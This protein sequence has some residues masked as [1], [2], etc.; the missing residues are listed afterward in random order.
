MAAWFLGLASLLAIYILIGYPIILALLRRRAAPAVKKNLDH[1]KT[2]TVILP[3]HNGAAFLAS[4]LESLL[5]QDYPRDLV[6]ILVASDGSTDATG[7]IARSYSDRGVRLISLP[8]GGKSAAVNG[9][10]EQARGDILFF[11]DVRQRLDTEALRHLVANFADPTVGAVTGEMVLTRGS[12]S[13][14]ANLDLYWRYE[15]WARRRHSEIDSV[16]NATGCIY[17]IRREL[18][19]PIPPDTLSDDAIIPLRAFFRGYRVLFDPAA[20]AFDF[21]AVAGT[22]FRRRWRNLAGLWQVH[23]RMPELFSSRNRMRFHFLSH[24]FARLVLPWAMLGVLASTI[25]LP[26]SPWRTSLLSSEAAFVL[27]AAIGHILP[28]GFPLQRL[29]SAAFTFLSMNLAALLGLAV[30][31]VPAQTLWQPT[32]VDLP[33]DSADRP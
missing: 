6:E 30:F 20:K 9:A 19:S 13:E 14:Q 29:G 16:F 3:V 12:E 22:E 24:K 31:F 1:R 28:R 18:V 4:K 10:I 5:A 26:S 15:V 8:R 25:A 32:R 33:E 2:V 7:D 21:P 17:A 27:L 23:A 11:T